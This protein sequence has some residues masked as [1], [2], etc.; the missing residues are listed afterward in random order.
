M[1]WE[2]FFRM[3][4]VDEKGA[5]AKYELALAATT[6]PDLRA[7]LERLRDEEVFHAEYLED[8]W[9]RLADRLKG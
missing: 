4:I 3:M 7:V 6:D 8:N 1:N 9:A 2:Q 5:R